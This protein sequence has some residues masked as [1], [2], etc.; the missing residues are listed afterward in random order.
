MILA[1]TVLPGVWPVGRGLL[2][3]LFPDPESTLFLTGVEQEQFVAELNNM[4]LES[5]IG[6]EI[7]TTA[8]V[9]ARTREDIAKCIRYRR[10]SGALSSGPPSRVELLVSLLSP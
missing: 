9:S 7:H 5:L 8:L 10:G 2:Q 3:D 1:C 4:L 6:T